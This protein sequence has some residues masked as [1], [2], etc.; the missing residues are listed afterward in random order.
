MRE[1]LAASLQNKKLPK[2]CTFHALGA[3]LLKRNSND[4]KLIKD[5]ERLEI[6]RALKKL[7]EFKSLSLRELSLVISCAKT[8]LEAPAGAAAQLLKTY[9]AALAE[10]E[11]HDYDDLLCKSYE[12]LKIDEGKRP[13]Y[14]YVLVDEFQDMSELQYGLV[15]LLGA[16][17][18]IF[19]I[20]DPNQSIYGWRGA[21][22]E[23]FEKFRA[24]FPN[25]QEINLT[26]SYRSR[27]EIINLA[28]AIFPDSPQLVP[29][30]K[31]SRPSP[32]PANTQR[33][34]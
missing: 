23:M 30:K 8:S 21:G 10:R 3:E 1:R 16:G 28:N 18:N 6:I 15:K 29:H 14:R 17:E 34:Q 11:L 25:I 12:L 26:I 24:D 7:A 31:N 13:N 4:Q 5:P 32:S 2:I 19:A 27:P 33:I 20:G 22:A 9:E